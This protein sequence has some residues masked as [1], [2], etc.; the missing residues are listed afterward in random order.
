[1]IDA[2][3]SIEINASIDTVWEYI[4]DIRR[5]AILFPGCREC[6]VIDERDS[7][8]TLKVGAGGL[9]RT[10]NVLVHVDRW[11]GP[12]RVNFSF[13]LDGDPVEGAGSYCAV[14]RSDDTTEASLSVR[15]QGSGPMA[16]M[17]EAV[18]RPLLPTLAKSFAAKLKEE[19]EKAI[20][21]PS[22]AAPMPKAPKST[23]ANLIKRFAAF[24]GLIHEV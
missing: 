7:Q 6:R 18:S 16:P 21:S 4:K 12:E 20:T 22:D 5:W 17:W 19:I 15:V 23:L 1:M 13:K 24:L 11:A 2:T 8:W 10:V 3:H 9:V 14:S